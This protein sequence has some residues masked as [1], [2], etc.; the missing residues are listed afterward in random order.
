MEIKENEFQGRNFETGAYRDTDVGKHDYEGF[1]SPLVIERFGAYM[2]SHRTQSD[3]RRRNSDNWQLGIPKKQYIKSA[4]R[5]FV[6]M[7]KWH[8]GIP[9]KESIE[10]AICALMFNVMGYLHELLKEKANAE[11]EANRVDT[12]VSSN[13]TSNCVGTVRDIDKFPQAGFR[14]SDYNPSSGGRV[15]ECNCG[16]GVCG[17]PSPFMDKSNTKFRASDRFES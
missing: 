15:S 4:W 13:I 8:R 6:D 5:H 11:S 12:G 7:W 17:S 9:C 16:H 3:G 10:E 2:E 14:R 1:F